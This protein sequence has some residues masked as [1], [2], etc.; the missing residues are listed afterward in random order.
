MEENDGK[1]PKNNFFQDLFL[2]IWSW[3]IYFF[4]IKEKYGKVYNDKAEDL[5]RYEIYLNNIA[6]I[7]THNMKYDEGK[8][9][10]WQ[11]PNEYID[12]VS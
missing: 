10:Y 7:N 2:V 6:D 12:W 4:F 9:S 1:V 3:S 8:S 11:G 5:E